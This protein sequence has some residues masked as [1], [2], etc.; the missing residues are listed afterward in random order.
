V[1]DTNDVVLLQLCGPEE[2][3]IDMHT[4]QFL[5]KDPKMFFGVF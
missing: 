1:R 4:P 5:L 2:W 3:H